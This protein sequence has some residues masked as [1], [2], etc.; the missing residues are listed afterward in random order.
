[1]LFFH[2]S[3]ESFISS[4]YLC[5]LKILKQDETCIPIYNVALLRPV[6]DCADDDGE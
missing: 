6:G 1:M 2:K 4:S 5:K 3:R